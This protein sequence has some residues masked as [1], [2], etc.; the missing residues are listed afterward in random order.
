MK[1]TI[2]LILILP[3]FIFSQITLIPDPEFE[4]ILIQ[5]NL[6]T[7]ADGQVLTSNISTLDTL[8]VF[9]GV[10]DL[11]GIEDF[12]SLTYLHSNANLNSINLNNNI[13]LKYLSVS[14]NNLSSLDIS[15]NTDLEELWFYS[16]QLT[17][18]DV[19][20]NQNLTHLFC[21]YKL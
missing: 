9:S 21:S 13:N 6:D 16:T 17:N 8:Y 7:V 11:T 4:Q 5:M 15:S 1:K 18:I 3:Q 10:T 12:V 19:S 20:S 14:N 2:T